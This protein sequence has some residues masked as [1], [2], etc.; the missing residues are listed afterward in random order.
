M[1]FI[2]TYF[3][4]SSWQESRNRTCMVRGSAFIKDINK[5]G[6]ELAIFLP[7]AGADI[8]SWE[9]ALHALNGFFAVVALGE[10]ILF[11]AVDR[12]RSIPLFYGRFNNQLFLSD[13]AE[14]V[15][16]Q[17]GDKE[18]DPVA[19]EEFLL[20][21]YVTGQ[22][23]LCPNVKQLQAGE[24]LVAQEH[25]QGIEVSCHRYYRF[26]HTE[27]DHFDEQQLRKTLDQAALQSVKRLVDYAGGRQIVIPLSGGYDSR[28]IAALLKRLGYEN[29]LAFSYGV[30]GNK[31]S[32]YSKKVAD[33][34]GIPWHFVEYSKD[35]WWKAWQTEESAD[36]QR[37]ASGWASL[38][39][40]QD[41]LAVR[42]M[43]KHNVVNWNCIFSPGHT[44]DFIS[45]GHIPEEANAQ[46]IPNIS[47]LFQIIAKKHYSISP[48]SR[49]T[50]RSE[51]FWSKRVC[52]RSEKNIISSGIELADAFEKWEWQERQAKF[53]CNSLRIYEYYGYDWW[54]P[55]WDN[56]FMVFWQNMPLELRKNRHWYTKHVKDVYGEMIGNKSN[57]M[58]NA[59]RYH[60]SYLIEVITKK[61]YNKSLF[62]ILRRRRLFKDAKNH[63]LR[64][65]NAF[66]EEKFKN[67]I[68]QGYRWHG[69]R[70][71]EILYEFEKYVKD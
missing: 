41:W 54:M 35:K 36:Y 55:L 52:N 66:P 33:N 5:S 34:L 59:S 42:E 65:W 3:I 53:I 70:A 46:H 10:N 24:Y 32:K 39:H 11:A 38:P 28:L 7:I 23:T 4:N 49:I 62:E 67:Y 14:W 37:W 12:I 31:E 25:E 21:G 45:G 2:K 47:L 60:R 13:D 15:R 19:R 17:V 50:S 6:S 30:H 16:T 9:N 51:E 29:I 61:I 22:D 57:D 56:E 64:F 71:S 48:W 58:G 8:E 44:G 26:T 68:F 43:S 18:M 40:V 20:T 1:S 69:M 27:P 63:P